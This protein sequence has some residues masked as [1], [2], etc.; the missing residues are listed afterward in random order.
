MNYRTLLFIPGNNPG[1]LQNSD[2]LGADGLIIDLEDA[3]AL[4]EK[5]AARTLVREYLTTF[6]TTTDVF[7]RIN[8]LD[9]PYFYEDLEAIKDLDIKGI[10]LPKA[11]IEPMEKLDEYLNENNLEFDIIA[12]VETAL[13]LELALDIV[14][15]SKRVIGIFLGAEDLTLDLGAKRTKESK[16]IQYARSR[17]IAASKALGI[18]AI[19]TPFTDT[20][21]I[22]GLKIDTQNAKN[23]GMTGKTVISPRHVDE[24]N[25]L[26]S[27]S[28]ADIE[29]A[30]RVVEGV[31]VANE[32][33]LGAFSIEGKMID[34]PIILRALNTLKLSGQYKEEYDELLK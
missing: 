18:Q 20:D 14:Q 5:D 33:G 3:V 11:G 6:D 15:R 10:V 34:K 17:I 12:L 23:L 19:D 32:K 31:K 9:S 24:V 27:P 16:E 30:L 2:I 4:T 1:M 7:I 21:D 28:K 29:Y 26:F 22:E 8:P 25:T 13:G